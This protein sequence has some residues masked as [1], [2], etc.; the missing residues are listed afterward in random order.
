MLECLN[1]GVLNCVFN[2]F[3]LK[4]T[5]MLRIETTYIKVIMLALTYLTIWYGFFI[6][7]YV[8]MGWFS[9]NHG[10]L[11]LY[12][13]MFIIYI[14]YIFFE[15][16]VYKLAVRDISTKTYL[17]Y[18][19]ISVSAYTHTF[20]FQSLPTIMFII[21]GWRKNYLPVTISLS[22]IYWLVKIIYL[23]RN[24]IKGLDAKIYSKVILSVVLIILQGVATTFIHKLHY[25]MYPYY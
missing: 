23:Y 3:L 19:L 24:I 10:L 12:A 11:I 4:R 21:M 18:L 7:L 25:E 17:S 1:E 9:Y 22:V 13:G 6:P 5:N 15:S 16:F 20:T 14:I 2:S 8:Y